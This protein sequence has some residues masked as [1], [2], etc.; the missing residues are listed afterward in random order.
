MNVIVTGG[1]GFVGSY[2]VGLMIGRGY[3]VTIV[4]RTPNRVRT[5]RAGI[6]VAPWLPA[7]SGYDAVVHLAGEN[8]VGKRWSPAQ[9]QE[10]RRSRIETTRQIVQ[11]IEQAEVRPPVL[12]SASAIGYYGH[13]PGELLDEESSAGTGFVPELCGAW[14]AEAEKAG[15]IGGVRVVRLRVGVVLGP[16]GGALGR[17]LTPF[18]WGLGGPLGNGKQAFS[19]IHQYDLGQMFLWAI[20]QQRVSGILDGV[21][22]TP[23]TAREFARTLGRVL[24]RPALVPAPAFALRLALGEVADVLLMD[25]RVLPTK[26]LRLGFEFRYPELEPALRE[27][28]QRFLIKEQV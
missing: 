23:V 9:K 4:S 6:K 13:R 22:P 21:G 19:W 1:T 27:L 8:L 10:L 17:M 2:L 7:L 3:K 5:A 20:E 26:A 11:K 14:E 16:Q 28:L 18:R 12:V 24:H 15:E 25:Q